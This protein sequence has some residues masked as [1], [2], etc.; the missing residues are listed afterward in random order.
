MLKCK[1]C[2]IILR[3]SSLDVDFPGFSF[4]FV[5]PLHAVRGF[6]FRGSSHRRHE[7]SQ[8]R[9][10]NINYTWLGF[11]IARLSKAS[12]FRGALCL[13]TSKLAAPP[14]AAMFVPD[15]ARRSRWRA[16]WR[17][18]AFGATTTGHR[19]WQ[20]GQPNRHR[21]SPMCYSP[22]KQK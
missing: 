21:T 16:T 14:R 13:L 9:W 4:F 2:L 6:L 5:L 8:S 20:P 17:N 22:L 7:D 10:N 3:R 15:G 18:D 11:L 19:P 1:Y 12:R